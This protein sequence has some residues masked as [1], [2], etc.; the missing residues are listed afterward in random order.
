MYVM[1]QGSCLSNLKAYKKYKIKMLKNEFLIKLTD[2][3]R[4]NI[5]KQDT[6]MAVD[7]CCRTIL[8]KRL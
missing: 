6:E 4:D 3:E 5:N 1:P 7:R 2:E 8:M